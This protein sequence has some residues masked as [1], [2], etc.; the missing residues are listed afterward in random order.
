MS[1]GVI[2]AIGWIGGICFS[3]CGLPQV[4]QCYRQKHAHGINMHFIL[5]WLVGELLTLIYVI[6]SKIYSAPLIV[7]YVFNIML[8]CVIL[9]YRVKPKS[10]PL[11]PEKPKPCG[12]IGDLADMDYI[13]FSTKEI[14]MTYTAPMDGN[15]HATLKAGDQVKFNRELEVGDG[16]VRVSSRKMEPKK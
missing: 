3:L 14:G 8:I 2:E 16:V 1:N 13:D 5:L 6:G 12:W 15:Y 11:E 4:L 7:N 10:E 9:Y